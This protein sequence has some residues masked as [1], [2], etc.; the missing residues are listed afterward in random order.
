[1]LAN[2]VF[3]YF[4][5]VYDKSIWRQ[6]ISKTTV[7]SLYHILYQRTESLQQHKNALHVRVLV[8]LYIFNHQF[9]NNNQSAY[10][11]ILSGKH[12]DALS[13]YNFFFK[14]ENTGLLLVLM[15]PQF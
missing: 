4:F 1:M 6:N 9:S 14:A 5:L 13:V 11:T 8:N 12:E 10:L 2:E 7:S 3:N 15:Q